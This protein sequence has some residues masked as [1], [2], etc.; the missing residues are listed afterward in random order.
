MHLP[1][2]DGLRGVAILV[3][4]IHTFGLLDAPT[5]L[6][7]RVF[8]A[9]MSQGWVG[10]QLFFVLSGFLITGILFDTQGAENYYSGFYARRV[11]RI[12]PLY[13]GTLLLTLVIL[14]VFVSLPAPLA[15]DR[16]YGI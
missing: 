6:A 14:P 8:G 7:G 16:Q 5:T 1:A 15:H 3:V 12:F 10:V 9:F 4:L 13:Y 2:L 11:L